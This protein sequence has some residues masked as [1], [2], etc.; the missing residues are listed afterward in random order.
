MA[1][2]CI[3][4]GDEVSD[5]SVVDFCESC[6]IGVWGEKMFS[7]II[8]NM[9]EAKERGDILHK[10]PFIGGEEFRAPRKF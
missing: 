5:E 10:G 4:C 6:G 7:A 8:K 2:K 1:K 3:Y 9:E